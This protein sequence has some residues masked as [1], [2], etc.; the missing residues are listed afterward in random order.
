MKKKEGINYELGKAVGP[1]V[2][3]KYMSQT[4]IRFS[5]VQDRTGETLLP[6]IDSNIEKDSTVVSDEWTGYNRLYEHEY[7]HETVNHSENYV[8]LVT[9]FYTQAIERV[10]GG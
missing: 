7:V 2:F 8:N 4:R 10:E 5:V 3:G 6:L 9:G 1:W